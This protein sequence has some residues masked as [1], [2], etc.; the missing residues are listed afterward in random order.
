[1]ALPRRAGDVEGVLQSALLP[2]ALHAERVVYQQPELLPL[3][4]FLQ[5]VSAHAGW[6]RHPADAA[7]YRRAGGRGVLNID[8]P[9]RTPDRRGRDFSLPSR[10]RHDRLAA[11]GAGRARAARRARQSPAEARR[12]SRRLARPLRLRTT[13][14]TDWQRLRRAGETRRG[15]RSS[16]LALYTE[17]PN[18]AQSLIVGKESI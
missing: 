2:R 11:G 13:Y 1:M 16:A 8:I 5:R 6:G 17:E 14:V 15:R 3:G 12:L 7:L 18:V 9:G 10:R 4:V